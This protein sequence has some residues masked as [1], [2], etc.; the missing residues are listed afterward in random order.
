MGINIGNSDG[1]KGKNGFYS[2]VSNKFILKFKM[3][4]TIQPFLYLLYW[5]NDDFNNYKARLSQRSTENLKPISTKYQEYL[6]EFYLVKRKTNKKFGYTNNEWNVKWKI[7]GIY[8]FNAYF[9][10]KKNQKVYFEKGWGQR[11]YRDSDLGATLPYFYIDGSSDYNNYSTFVAVYEAHN[12]LI[13]DT[14]KSVS[15]DDQLN[16]NI[17]IKI[18]TNKGQDYILSTTNNNLISSFNL[19]GN[20]SVGVKLIDKNTIDKIMIGGNYF[21]NIQFDKREYNGYTKKFN[22]DNN[23]SYFEIE[24]KMK[25]EEL[26][27]QSLQII[28]NDKIMRTYPIFKA[29]NIKEGMKIYTRIN[30]KGFKLYENVY[31]RIQTVKM[32]KEIIKHKFIMNYVK[33][34]I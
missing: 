23:N 15:V 26:I 5:K 7:D 21:D 3:R 32:D 2:Y 18:I 1:I 22:N 29:E 27:G 14:V 16:G 30:Q 20:P 13:N 6:A 34:N 19:L 11:D 33:K 25:K 28:G 31:W 12:N 24:T 17:G 9:P 4:G 10:K 8:S